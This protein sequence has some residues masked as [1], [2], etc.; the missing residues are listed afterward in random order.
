[1]FQTLAKEIRENLKEEI[2]YEDGK[3]K[4][5]INLNEAERQQRE[6]EKKG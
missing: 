2:N 3:K 4:P 6:K 1:L 5:G